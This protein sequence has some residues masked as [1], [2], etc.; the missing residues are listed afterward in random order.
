[1]IM[2]K[3]HIALGSSEKR[4]NCYISGVLNSASVGVTLFDPSRLL[5]FSQDI[6]DFSQVL[7]LCCIWEGKKVCSEDCDIRENTEYNVIFLG[8]VWVV[9]STIATKIKNSN[10]SSFRTET[11]IENS[12]SKIKF[13][14]AKLSW[15]WSVRFL[16]R[17]R[18]PLCDGYNMLYRSS[19]NI[20]WSLLSL[21]LLR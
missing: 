19:S 8:K 13:P 2:K 10:D 7:R 9:G 18:T 14:S 1:M 11:P 15:T 12:S 16:R 5:L 21:L 4:E 17:V 20:C 3:W 6:H